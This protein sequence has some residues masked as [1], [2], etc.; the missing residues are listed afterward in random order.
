MGQVYN[1]TSRSDTDEDLQ[2]NA[3]RFTVCF[4]V[5][6]ANLKF[7]MNTSNLARDSSK[8]CC[9]F[10]GDLVQTQEDKKTEEK[11][12]QLVDF[13]NEKAS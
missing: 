5:F 9:V 12:N 10:L 2:E 7:F 1:F 11:V 13:M 3:E 4:L 8:I 6:N